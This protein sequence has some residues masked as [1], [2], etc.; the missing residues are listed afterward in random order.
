MRCLAKI[1]YEIMKYRITYVMPN[2]PEKE[3]V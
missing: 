2:L 1:V 3:A